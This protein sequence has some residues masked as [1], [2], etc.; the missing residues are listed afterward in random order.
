MD[1]SIPLLKDTS[2]DSD[3]RDAP[4]WDA[5]AGGDNADFGGPEARR[6]LEK[7]LLWKLDKRMSILILIYIL[8]FVRFL[9][10]E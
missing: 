2:E 3:E 10:F 9:A 5:E 4:R 1:P 6:E 7:K 8:N